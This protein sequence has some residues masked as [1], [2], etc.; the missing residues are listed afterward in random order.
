MTEQ[1]ETAKNQS[2]IWEMRAGKIRACVW[3]TVKETDEGRSYPDFST[4]IEKS[5]EIGGRWRV[6]S[7][8]FVDELP[9]LLMLSM[10]AY[11]FILKS[12]AAWFKKSEPDATPAD[13]PYEEDVPC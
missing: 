8:F 9:A 5:Y 6:T 3:V 4:K 7:Y 10:A 13:L 12:R 1:D 2:P 11:Q